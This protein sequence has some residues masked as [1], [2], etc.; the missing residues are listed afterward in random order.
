MSV[1]S[2]PNFEEP[3]DPEMSGSGDIRSCSFSS[4]LATRGLH[5]PVI[6][7]SVASQAR[8]AQCFF[9]TLSA[10][11]S[12][13][14]VTT[15]ADFLASSHEADLL[16]P[17]SCP[18]NLLSDVDDALYPDDSATMEVSECEWDAATTS[19]DPSLHYDQSL[20]YDPSL[21]YDYESHASIQLLQLENRFISNYNPGYTTPRDIH[22]LH[23]FLSRPQ[24]SAW[25]YGVPSRFRHSYSEGGRLETSGQFVRGRAFYSNRPGGRHRPY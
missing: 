7:P 2:L 22:G 13:T 14:A 25:H 16:T 11:E 12:N 21:H 24:S 8:Y 17:A 20:H 19:Y 1:T 15:S 23:G 3:I 4:V 9:P 5:T 10:S 18:S 6:S